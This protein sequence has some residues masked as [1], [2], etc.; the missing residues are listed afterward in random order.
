MKRL[1]CR[2]PVPEITNGHLTLNITGS[3]KTGIQPQIS[4]QPYKENWPI[5]FYVLLALPGGEF[6]PHTMKIG[7][8]KWEAKNEELHV[9]IWANGKSIQEDQ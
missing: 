6:N 7:P 5:S 3:K 8:V 9:N 4:R 2:D 1:N